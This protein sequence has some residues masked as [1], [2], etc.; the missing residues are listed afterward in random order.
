[1]VRRCS[2]MFIAS[3]LFSL[4]RVSVTEHGTGPLGTLQTDGHSS[5]AQAIGFSHHIASAG[6]PPER[7]EKA[8]P[9]CPAH[10]FAVWERCPPIGKVSG[11]TLGRLT[12]RGWPE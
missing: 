9:A 2:P 1:M 11:T 8:T 6:K 12:A 7:N 5:L 4:Q 10:Q 3:P